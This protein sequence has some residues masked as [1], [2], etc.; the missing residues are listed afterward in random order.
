[1]QYFNTLP[2]IVYRSPSGTSSLYTN[3]MA[4]ASIIP[5]VLKD[6]MVYYKYDIQEGDTPEIVAYKYYGD[7]YRYWIVLFSNQIMDPQW[8]W[9]LS[10]SVFESYIKDKYGFNKQT[11]TWNVLNP[12]VTTY[13]WQKIIT[14]YDVSTQTTTVNTLQIDE[15]TYDNLVESTTIYDKLTTGQV[16]IT[17][18]KNTLTYYDWELQKN[19]SKRTINLLNENYVNQLEKEFKNLIK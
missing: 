2:K 8:E 7:S 19:E 3:L 15:D 1:M 11:N 9:P 13:I 18:S 6:P 5:S 16:S 4:R 12:Y 17:I 14:Q 10:Y